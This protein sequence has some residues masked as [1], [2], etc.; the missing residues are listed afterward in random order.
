M[1]SH[2][3][4]AIK[5]FWYEVNFIQGGFL[6]EMQ[7]QFWKSSSPFLDFHLKWGES[8]HIHISND[9]VSDQFNNRKFMETNLLSP[10][11][12]GNLL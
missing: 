8:Q 9:R 7:W 2:L 6:N 1:M 10:S 3:L 12:E 4:V 5:C 11:F